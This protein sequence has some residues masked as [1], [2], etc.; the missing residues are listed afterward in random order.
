MVRRWRA[1]RRCLAVSGRR[2]ER[3]GIWITL[4]VAAT[5]CTAMIHGVQSRLRPL[6]AAAVELQIHDQVTQMIQTTAAEE[7]DRLG[8]A[9]ND[10]VTVQRDGIGQIL[11]L[12][13][14]TAAMTRLQS[15]LTS[16]A[17]QGIGGLRSS[18]LAIPVGSLTGSDL[19][20]GRGPAIQVRSLWVGTVEAVFESELDSAGVNQTQHRIWLIFRVPVRVLLPGGPVE[21][22]VNV[23]FLTA[24]TVIVGQVPNTY[25]SLE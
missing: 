11:G 10:L 3:R 6:T 1:I 8:V 23:R 13:T 5:L 17:L 15:A 12:T 4:V 2:R 22:T 19:F 7:L 20:W 16:A 21:T 14:D 24:E 18:A 9:Y 25:L